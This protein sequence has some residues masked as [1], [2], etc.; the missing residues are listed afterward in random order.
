M[1]AVHHEPP[2][3]VLDGKYALLRELGSGGTGTVYEAEN[4]I[5]GKKVAIKVLS[6]GA[7]AEQDSHARFVTEARAAA[8]I[9]HANVVDIHDLGVGK[10]G[11]PYIVME[12][13][14]G[15]T[16]ESIIDARGPLAP[17]FA[18]ELFLQVLAG[19]SA[20]HAQGIVHCDLK[21]ANVLV[22]YP[23]PDRPLVKV[24]DFGIARGVEAASQVDQVVMGTP[25][26]MAPEQVSGD[27]VDFRT[28]VYQACAT[29]FA[30]LSGQDPFEAYTTRD[31]MKLVAKG[32]CRDLQELA[33]DLPEELVSIVKDGMKVKR[34][35]RIQSAEELAERVRPFVTSGNLVSLVP[36]HR[37]G[38]GKPLPTIIGPNADQSN[39]RAPH[40][41]ASVIPVQMPSVPR[42]TDSLLVSPRIPRPPSTPKL[43]M[44]QDF[45]PMPGDPQY[46]ELV[47]ARRSQTHMPKRRSSFRHDVMPALIATSVGF[48]LGMVM[49]WSA[50]LL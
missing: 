38:S 3:S 35:D 10:N 2:V 19:L 27:P 20:A 21:P 45:M 24:L 32:R 29:L 9:S 4:L 41:P 18:C 50:G 11:I 23:R 48:G 16:L 30:I 43:R 47:D 26:Y 1:S 34:Q 5:V 49:A 40:P 44:G 46:Q 12:L 25:I 31:V 42:A 13:L 22:T 7:F 37:T 39:A 6:P 8:R 14:R 36:V 17:A 33:P 28:D 15:E